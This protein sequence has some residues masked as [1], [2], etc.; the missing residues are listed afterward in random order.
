[1]KNKTVN[2]EP[3]LMGVIINIQQMNKIMGKE[4]LIKFSTLEAMTC[5]EL[6]ELQDNIIKE[7]RRYMN[8]VNYGNN[9]YN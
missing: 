4:D 5:E 3:T 8:G 1:M 9:T 6:H 2:Q 7:Y